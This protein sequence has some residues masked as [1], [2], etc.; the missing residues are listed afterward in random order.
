MLKYNTRKTFEIEGLG[1]MTMEASTWNYFSMI[2]AEASEHYYAMH[3]EGL[4][5]MAKRRADEIYNKLSEL[6][7]YD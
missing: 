6:G 3:L 7:M 5:D 2:C 4:G 1:K